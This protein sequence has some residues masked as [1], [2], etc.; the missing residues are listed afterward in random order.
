M[1]LSNRSLFGRLDKDS[2]RQRSS[3][4]TAGRSLRNRNFRVFL[5]GQG[6]SNTGMWVQQ[7]AELWVIL[8]LTG[9]GAAL[10]LHS[11][12]RFGPILVFGV[13]GGLFTDRID[14][15]KLLIATQGLHTVSTTT[16]TIAAWL[17]SASLPLIYGVVL[18][19]GLVNAV[20]NPLRRGF[21]RDLSSDEEL[22]NAVSL[23]GTMGTVTRTIGPAI[24]GLLITAFGVEW[25]FGINAVSYVAVLASL[26]MIDRGALRPFQPVLRGPGQLREGFRY[27]LGS[28][29]IRTTLI[30]VAVLSTFAWNWNVLLPVY[31]TATFGG[32][33]SL[34]GL[35]QSL[36]SIG[37][38]VGALAIARVVRPQGRH[39]IVWGGILAASL[40]VTAT[41][42]VLAVGI[43]GLVLLGMAG[44]SFTIAAQARLQIN[45]DDAMSGR[46]M[47]LFT[48]GWVGSKPVGGLIGG[49]IMDA[50]GPRAAFGVGGVMVGLAVLAAAIRRSNQPTHPG[51]ELGG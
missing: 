33:A 14:R 24:G 29:W 9:S 41:A 27:A 1:R 36:L 5:I 4:K 28:D 34:Y 2:G 20:D 7:T 35:L 46:I 17:G 49:W 21:I 44:T 16:L 38:F 39:L 26:F 32:D 30:L 37:S 3:W 6:L 11:L 19:Q 47:A 10:G 25:C 8:Q 15:R 45:V 50:G 12:L 51:K 22:A 48:V 40:A 13:Y 42:P 18:A 23:N 31:A 43:A